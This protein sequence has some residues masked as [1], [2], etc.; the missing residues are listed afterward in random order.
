VKTYLSATVKKN[1]CGK[2][3]DRGKVKER[4]KNLFFFMLVLEFYHKVCMD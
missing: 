2:K 1:Y 3:N 4:T